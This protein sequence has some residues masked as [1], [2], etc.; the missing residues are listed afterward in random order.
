MAP[1]CIQSTVVLFV[2]LL[3]LPLAAGQAPEESLLSAP[4][5]SGA[6][7]SGVPVPKFPDKTEKN[8]IGVALLGIACLVFV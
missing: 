4:S 6:G 2:G 1:T 5:G 7:T 8:L 3:L